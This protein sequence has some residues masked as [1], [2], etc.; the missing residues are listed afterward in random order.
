MPQKGFKMGI[1]RHAKAVV[2][3][4]SALVFHDQYHSKDVTVTAA[5]Q[6]AQKQYALLLDTSVMY[7]DI[8]NLKCSASNCSRVGAA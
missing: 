4:I 7:A 1:E 2:G 8:L 6:T 3:I 5:G